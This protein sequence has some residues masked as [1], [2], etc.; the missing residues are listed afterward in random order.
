M[1]A[2]QGV[3]VR[4]LVLEGLEMVMRTQT[5]ARLGPGSRETPLTE[6]G[7]L[8]VNQESSDELVGFP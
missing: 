2:E 6:P 4:E 7:A 5:A 3:T 8:E 1:A